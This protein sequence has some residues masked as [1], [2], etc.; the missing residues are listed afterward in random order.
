[1]AMIHQQLYQTQDFENINLSEYTR[2]LLIN[3]SNYFSLEEQRIEVEMNVPMLPFPVDVAIPFGL[4]LNELVSNSYKY[5]FAGKTRGKIKVEVKK[6]TKSLYQ[7]SVSDDGNGLPEDMEKRSEKSLGINLVKGIA[8]QLRGKLNYYNTHP[9]S[10][11][12]V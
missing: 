9:G 5:G 11:F 2:L 7:L 10:T 6:M 4:I 8:W 1:M 3:I 12:E